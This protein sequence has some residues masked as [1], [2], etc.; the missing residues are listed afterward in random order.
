ME[1]LSCARCSGRGGAR[2]LPCSPLTHPRRLPAWRLHR[3]RLRGR[4]A[5]PPAPSSP[6][7]ADRPGIASLPAPVARAQ[8]LGIEPRFAAYYQDHDGVRLLGLPLTQLHEVAGIPAQT[9]DKGRLEDHRGA[10]ADPAWALMFGRLTAELLASAPAN[11]TVSG[12]S[13]T[14]G[15]L[16]AAARPAGRLTPPPGFRG[17]VQEVTL[18]DGGQAVFIPVDPDL[19]PAPGYA[20]PS[21]FWKAMNR[22]ELFPGGWLHDLGLPLTPQLAAEATKGGKVRPVLVQAFERS[23]LTLDPHN[24]SGWEVERGNLGADAL[25]AFG[26]PT[27]QPIQYPELGANVT[28]PLHLGAAVG[29]PGQQVTARLRWADGTELAQTFTLLRGQDSRGLLL[30]SL[31]WPNLV[32]PPAPPTQGASL[33]LRDQAGNLLARRGVTVLGPG[34]PAARSVWVYWTIVGTERTEPQQRQVVIDPG[35]PRPG[36]WWALSDTERLAVAAL[37]ELL[38]GPPAVSQAGFGTAI[39]TPA[40]VLSDPGRDPDWGQRVAL[41]GLSIGDGVATVYLS[42]A[43]RAYGGHPLRARLIREQI[44]LT[45]LQFPE[46]QS[47]RIGIDGQTEGVLEP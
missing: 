24:P 11:T 42:P 36:H 10:V 40:E 2:L 31:E 37:E 16:R 20:V 9:F 17:G 35:R 27:P 34:D 44:T 28:V 26:L 21:V 19:R 43:L 6:A 1:Q 46:V 7:R 13:L 5:L 23:V 8:L 12:T 25:A 18:P 38:W 47:V 14:Y 15:A 29:E 30:A 22:P 39:P 4:Y 32:A 45:L 33:E 41:Q 3:F